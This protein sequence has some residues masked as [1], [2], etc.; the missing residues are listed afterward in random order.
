LSCTPSLGS[1]CRR[2][3]AAATACRRRPPSRAAR[4][5]LCFYQ[6]SWF[7]SLPCA[8][9]W[10]RCAVRR[11]PRAPRP[12][13][14][15]SGGGRAARRLVAARCPRQVYAQTPTLV[16]A[17]PRRARASPAVREANA[18]LLVSAR[19][20][21]RRRGRGRRVAASTFRRAL[22]G[23][24]RASRARRGGARSLRADAPGLGATPG[25]TATAGL[26]LR[27]SW[28]LSSVPHPSSARPADRAGAEP[29]ARA[30][31]VAGLA[32]CVLRWRHDL[33]QG[34]LA[35]GDGAKQAVS[36]LVASRCRGARCSCFL[37]AVQRGGAPRRGHAPERAR[38]APWRR[39]CASD[40]PLALG[41]PAPPLRW[42]SD[43]GSGEAPG[44]R[45]A[46]LRTRCA[47]CRRAS[48]AG[49]LP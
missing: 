22:G 42:L 33:P 34:F 23:L 21:H 46:W 5:S 37:R 20:R 4:P 15:R 29:R 19:R 7:V 38:G 9:C 24:P 43:G 3:L 48:A 30:V 6:P 39:L 47:G 26:R 1:R 14:V 35:V 16:Q 31:A 25:P 13:C 11:R 8:P 41:F 44:R 12:P 45:P 36:A 32:L 10:R 28:Q 40:Q 27:R 18:P 2:A 49:D 17:R